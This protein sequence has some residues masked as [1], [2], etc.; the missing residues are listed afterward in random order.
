MKK[1]SLYIE[2][3]VDSILKIDLFIGDM[4]QNDFEI[5]QKTQSAVIMQLALIGELCKKV[6]EATKAEIDVPWKEIIGF[7]DRAVHDY[8]SVDLNVVWGTAKG[9]LIELRDALEN[10]LKNIEK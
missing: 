10:Y 6:S 4:N 7:R 3:I 5:D 1:D 9:D 8:Y 2:Q